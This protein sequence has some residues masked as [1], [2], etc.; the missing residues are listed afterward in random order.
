MNFY[1]L[2][3]NILRFFN[4]FTITFFFSF[5]FY[6][7]LIFYFPF[8]INRFFIHFSLKK[9]PLPLIRFLILI[10]FF[11]VFIK[12][13]TLIIRLRT[14]LITGHLILEL[15][16]KLIFIINFIFNLIIIIIEIIVRIIQALVFNLIIILYR[17]D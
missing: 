5:F 4:N 8:K 11:S 1:S 15:I 16:S 13:T 6:T 2:F 10:E 14:N 7:R 9:I 12:P 17:S 3:N